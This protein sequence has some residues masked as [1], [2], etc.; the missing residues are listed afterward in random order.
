MRDKTQRVAQ[1]GALMTGAGVFR[2]MHRAVEGKQSAHFNEDTVH[3]LN[4]TYRCVCLCTREAFHKTFPRSYTSKASSL[5][6]E[7]VNNAS[8]EI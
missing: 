8:S 4:D 3:S 2:A 6:E 5:Q 7:N 1:V